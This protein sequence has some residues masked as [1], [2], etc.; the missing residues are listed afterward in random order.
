MTRY[1]VYHHE[2]EYGSHTIWRDAWNEL[3]DRTGEDI[4]YTVETVERWANLRDADKP[5]SFKYPTQ[6]WAY[7]D[8][9]QIR[10]EQVNG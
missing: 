6:Q 9:W 1:T 4:L 2:T 10:R 8:G 7:P 5:P 3:L